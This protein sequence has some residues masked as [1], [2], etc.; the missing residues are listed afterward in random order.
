M[1]VGVATSEVLFEGLPLLARERSS[2]VLVGL[3][4][5]AEKEPGHYGRSGS[6][7][8]VVGVGGSIETRGGGGPESCGV[9]ICR[10]TSAAFGEMGRWL[11]P[12]QERNGASSAAISWERF[13]WL[14]SARRWSI[15]ETSTAGATAGGDGIDERGKEEMEG[16]GTSGLKLEACG[17]GRSLALCGDERLGRKVRCYTPSSTLYCYPPLALV[18]VD[19]CLWISAANEAFVFLQK[20]ATQ[21]GMLW[22]AG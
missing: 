6:T 13:F 17:G 14:V 8:G 7:E 12:G 11:R 16:G 5:S 21:V 3:A 2:P 20:V 10:R 15:E 4:A 18:V 22:S 9:D 1:R 19:M